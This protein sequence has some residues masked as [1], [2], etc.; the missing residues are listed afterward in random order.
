[1]VL[2]LVTPEDKEL[3]LSTSAEL[4]RLKTIQM[5]RITSEAWIQDGVLTTLD[6]ER[7]LGVSPAI[8]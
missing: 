8:T 3:P 1:V 7:L 5:E 2:S 4:K 6:M